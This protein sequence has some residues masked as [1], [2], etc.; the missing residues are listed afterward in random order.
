VDGFLVVAGLSG[1]GFMHGPVAGKLMT[2][3]ILDGSFKTVDVSALD[4]ARFHEGRLIQEY[5]VV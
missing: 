4:L 2:E 5:N 1:H 3:L